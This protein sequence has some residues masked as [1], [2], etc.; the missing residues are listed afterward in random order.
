MERLTAAAIAVSGKNANQALFSTLGAV[1]D[2]ADACSPGDD[3]T[4]LVLRRR[5]GITNEASRSPR[6]DFSTPHGRTSVAQPKK[7]GRGGNISK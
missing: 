7:A 2:F 4:L 6:K 1:L 5:E 3:L